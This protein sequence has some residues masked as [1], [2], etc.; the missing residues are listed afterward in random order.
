MAKRLAFLIQHEP[1]KVIVAI[2]GAGHEKEILDLIKKYLK[3]ESD[4]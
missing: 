4:K 2:V 1:E 3:R